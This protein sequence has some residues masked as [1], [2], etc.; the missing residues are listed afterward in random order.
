MVWGPGLGVCERLSV[1]GGRGWG[2]G[3]LGGWG[4]G[5]GG[6]QGD[7]S[8]IRVRCGWNV[9]GFMGGYRRDGGDMR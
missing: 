7:V 9:R 6:V 2:G 1:L 8:G 5:G 3:G 4:I